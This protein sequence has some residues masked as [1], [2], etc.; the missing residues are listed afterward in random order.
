MR[1]KV[2]PLNVRT[3]SS[4]L[5]GARSR[6]LMPCSAE[7]RLYYREPYCKCKGHGRGLGNVIDKGII[8]KESRDESLR[9]P[10]PGLREDVEAGARLA[11]AQGPQARNALDDAATSEAKGTELV[12]FT[13]RQLQ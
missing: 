12:P 1:I 9:R 10:S 8:A 4:V 7:G 11:V 3:G 2:S 13:S 5:Y 6:A